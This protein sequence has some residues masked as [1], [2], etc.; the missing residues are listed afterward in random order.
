MSKFPVFWASSFLRQMV[1]K[2]LL[3]FHLLGPNCLLLLLLSLLSSLV[4]S[5]S[6]PILGFLSF[7]S[8]TSL[9]SNPIPLS[10]GVLPVLLLFNDDVD[11]EN[12]WLLTSKRRVELSIVVVVVVIVVVVAI[13]LITPHFQ[14]FPNLRDLY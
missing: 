11:F 7:A 9:V 1:L 6:L 5:P 3:S 8:F 12:Y 14:E 13:R 2:V 4:S 10:F